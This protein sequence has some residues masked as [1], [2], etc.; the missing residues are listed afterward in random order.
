MASQKSNPEPSPAPYVAFSRV[1]DEL[2]TWAKS[3]GELAGDRVLDSMRTCVPFVRR[4]YLAQAKKDLRAKV[5]ERAS[6]GREPWGD[7]EIRRVMAGMRSGEAPERTAYALRR[8][9]AAVKYQ[10]LRI[11]AEYPI[12]RWEPRRK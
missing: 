7:A 3:H 6:R 2:E 1:V 12:E 9:V 5:D 11:K 10:I 8:T 4:A